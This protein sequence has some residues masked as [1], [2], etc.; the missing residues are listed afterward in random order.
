MSHVVVTT[1][2]LCAL[3]FLGAPLMQLALR[4]VLVAGFLVSYGVEALAAPSAPEGARHSDVPIAPTRAL[5]IRRFDQA[6][7]GDLA[8]RRIAA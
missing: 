2:G 3:V 5:P 6:G 4:C 8:S 7:A 1:I